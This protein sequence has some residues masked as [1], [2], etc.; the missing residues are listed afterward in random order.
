MKRWVRRAAEGWDEE[1]EE[2]DRGMD[3]D[4]EEMGEEESK[5]T[6]EEDNEE[7]GEADDEEM[8]K[9]EDKEMDEEGGGLGG[10]GSQWIH[11]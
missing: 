9:E 3:V 10:E 1:D 6:D 8:A 11:H 7:M 2:D 4:G 5:E